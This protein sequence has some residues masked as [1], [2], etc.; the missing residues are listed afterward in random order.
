MVH[1]LKIRDLSFL[2]LLSAIMVLVG[3]EFSYSQTASNNAKQRVVLSAKLIADGPEIKEG[4]EWRIFDAKQIRDADMK[5]LASSVGGTK[6]FDIP[7]GDYYVH[8]AYGHAGVVRRISV[9]RSALRQE[10]ILDAGGLKLLATASG[11]APLPAQ[12][13]SF[14]IYETKTDADGNRKLLAKGIKANEVI[15]FPIGTYS[16]ISFFGD[17]NA[18]VR[19][20]LRVEPGKLTIASLEHR[21]ALVRFRLVRTQGGDAIPDTAWSILTENGEIIK[22]SERTFPS[23]ALAE[24]NYTAIAK[25]ND[26]VFT[27]DFE[28]KSGYNQTVEVKVIN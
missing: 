20:E 5:E 24:G 19:A 1:F 2:A 10:F 27:Q 18:E 16:V 28:V 12:M 23:L 4:V 15:A 17:L 3:A 26:S 13:L 6:A 25:H 11:D 9:G 8:A 22:E 21:A 14:D 7:V